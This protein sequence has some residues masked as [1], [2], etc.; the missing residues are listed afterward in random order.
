MFNGN[1]VIDTDGHVMEPNDLYDRYLE[2]KFMPDLEE[3]KQETDGRASKFFFGIFHQLNTGR[4]LGV[5]HP[6]KP[7]VRTGRNPRRDK[8]DMRGG[9]DPHIRIKDMDREG[10]DIAVLFATVVSSF[11][12]LESVDF[13]VAMIRAYHR[14]LADYCS[15]Y[16]NRLKGVAVVP[17]RAPERAA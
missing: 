8:P 15:A 10:I 12:A 14:W 7:L 6:D 11:C 5:P 16:P 13:E 17:M 1:K 9:W 4:P 3:L 2:T